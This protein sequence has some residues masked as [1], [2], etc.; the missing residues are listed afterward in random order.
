MRPHLVNTLKTRVERYEVDMRG[1]RR[2]E[3][4]K[5]LLKVR[6]QVRRKTDGL[7][8]YCG[9]AGETPD[10]F[11]PIVKGGS[12]DI[13]N[14]FPSCRSCN[15][16]K[17]DLLL[18]EWR[19]SRRM[20]TAREKFG[21]PGFTVGQCC[22]L[23]QNVD[24]DVLQILGVPDIRFWFELKGIETPTGSTIDWAP[25]DESILWAKRRISQSRL[26]DLYDFCSDYD[27]RPK[28]V[29]SELKKI[30]ASQEIIN[31]LAGAS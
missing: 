29:I 16:S 12:D 19:V 25:S 20:K 3:A 8:F 18:E 31:D 30:G 13:D 26:T 6:E 10:H 27:V 14:L 23:R 2:L 28:V 7:C 15:N 9:E 17:G 22:W 21:I 5:A 1:L 24:C 4:T 11:I